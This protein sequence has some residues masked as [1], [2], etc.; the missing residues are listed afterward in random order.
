MNSLKY[1]IDSNLPFCRNNDVTVET[2]ITFAAQVSEACM[3][4][5]QN[6]YVHGWLAAHNVLVASIEQVKISD[7]SVPCLREE[8]LLQSTSE[9]NR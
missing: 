6:N 4:L 1:Y 2:L 7:V 5:H 8:E 3:Y 9:I